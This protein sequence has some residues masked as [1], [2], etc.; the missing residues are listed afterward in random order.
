MSRTPV[1][2]AFRRFGP[3]AR[4]VPA[5]KHRT[6]QSLSPLPFGVLAPRLENKNDQSYNLQEVVSIAFRRFGPPAQRIEMRY[7][8][9]GIRSP[10]PFGVL[11]PRL[12]GRLAV[13]IKGGG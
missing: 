4:A 9:N 10:L 2:I 13:T 7:P 5:L 6:A 11:A 1:S 12:A 8:A 3:P